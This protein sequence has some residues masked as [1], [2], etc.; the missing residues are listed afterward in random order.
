MICS[1]RLNAVGEKK[2]SASKHIN[3]NFSGPS[4]STRLRVVRKRR[5]KNRVPP[6]YLEK[7]NSKSPAYSR[8]S[9]KQHDDI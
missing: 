6:E 9:N 7:I 2:Q 4:P 1:A 3:N 5:V 8:K